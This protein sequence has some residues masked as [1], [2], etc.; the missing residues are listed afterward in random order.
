M[1]TNRIIYTIYHIDIILGRENRGYG[2][3]FLIIDSSDGRV[4]GE[5]KKERSVTVVLHSVNSMTQTL[6]CCS[7]KRSSGCCSNHMNGP[8]TVIGPLVIR[9]RYLIPH[10]SFGVE[11]A[12]KVE[13]CQY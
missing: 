3:G 13:F 1:L 5:K 12:W 10:W 9:S 7:I 6:P 4:D 8:F 11:G 2:A